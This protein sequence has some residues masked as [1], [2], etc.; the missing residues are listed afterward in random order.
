MLSVA[1]IGAAPGDPVHEVVLVD[2]WSYGTRLYLGR[3]EARRR[4]ERL[5]RYLN[6]GVAIFGLIVAFPL[7]VVIALAIKVASP[8]PVL[9]TQVRVGVD[10]RSPE[11]A[12]LNWRRRFDHGG[13]LFR[14]YKFRTMRHEAGGAAEQWARRDDPRVFPL[15]RFL[16]KY[17]LDELPQLLNVIKGD[18]NIV[19]PRP[20]QPGIF[21]ELREQIERYP[22]RQRVLPGITGLAQVTN[23]YDACVEDVRRKLSYDLMYMR[24][25][26]LLEDV[27]IMARTVP[28]VLLKKGGW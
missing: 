19:G 25:L 15:G 24:R 27:R 8:G 14:L 21:S 10:R 1:E 7:M 13:R 20:E 17:R 3:I 4:A 2:P 12:S 26:S 5:R 28:A 23:P 22:V 6:V 18:M 11:Q 16:R 9:F